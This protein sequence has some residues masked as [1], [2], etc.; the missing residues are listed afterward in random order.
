MA[1]PSPQLVQ[2]QSCSC[3]LGVPPG[4]CIGPE[5]FCSNPCLWTLLHGTSPLSS[6]LFF[7]TI[8]GQDGQ[9]V[10][11][12]G[13]WWQ[14][15]CPSPFFVLDTGC[16]E[17]QLWKWILSVLL[18]GGVNLARILYLFPHLKERGKWSLLATRW[19]RFE[20]EAAWCLPVSKYLVTIRKSPSLILPSSGFP[21]RWIKVFG[22]YPERQKTFIVRWVCTL[23]YKGLFRLRLSCPLV[24]ILM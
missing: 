5:C 23:V 18:P 16:G 13:P 11:H 8:W 2:D 7:I 20:D 22:K 17:S 1:F 21:C 10:S 3:W 9:T 4:P 12:L 14:Y 6:C 24:S 19:N 15:W